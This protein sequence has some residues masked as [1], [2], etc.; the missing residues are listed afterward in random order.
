LDI[1]TTIYFPLGEMMITPIDFYMLIA[2]PFEANSLKYYSDF[3]LVRKRHIQLFGSSAENWPLKS[4][5]VQY[6]MFK[7]VLKGSLNCHSY[8]HIFR[9]FI[10]YLL[11]YSIF[12][13][14]G[15]RCHLHWMTLKE[16][17]A[18]VD[19]LDWAP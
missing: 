6:S 12:I 3:K 13:D 4:N 5:S 19:D 14:K 15:N 16:D 17:V 10:I 8:E 11:S 18:A 2:F 1:I 9:L 7:K